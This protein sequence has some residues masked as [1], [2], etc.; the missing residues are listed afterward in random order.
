[1][2]WGM[3][4]LLALVSILC[5]LSSFGFAA[6]APSKGAE[7]LRIA[8]G[9]KVNLADYLVPGKT[10]I[11]DFTSKYCGPCRAYDGPLRDLHAKRP[12]LVVVQVDINRPDVEGIDWESSVAGQFD[13]HAIPHFKVYGPAG[14]LIAEDKLTLDPDGR[15]ISRD[16]AGRMMV[17]GWINKPE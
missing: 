8:H 9:E 12:D 16:P 13:L 4:R 17:D 3:K 10:V 1:M 7:P 11:F 2:V 14:K 15:P 6:A 5:F